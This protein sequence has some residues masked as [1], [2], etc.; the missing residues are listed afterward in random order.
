MPL[1]AKYFG[2]Q[3][4]TLRRRLAREGVKFSQIL[5]DYRRKDA[6]RLLSHGY[7]V[8]EVSQRL[9]YRRRALSNTLSKYGSTRLRTLLPKAFAE[10]L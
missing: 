1:A 6:M 5:Q 2:L 10:K 3:A 8:K 4:S 9:G 7:S